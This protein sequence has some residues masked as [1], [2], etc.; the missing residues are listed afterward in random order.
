MFIRSLFLVAVSIPALSFAQSCPVG[1]VYDDCNHTSVGPGPCIPGCVA[2]GNP[3]PPVD[4]LTGPAELCIHEA[5]Q[6]VSYRWAGDLVIAESQL[7]NGYEVLG[8]AGPC[9]STDRAQCPD[10]LNQAFEDLRINALRANR[11]QFY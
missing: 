11:A 3:I 9:L 4:E 10:I 6:S 7:A 2:S 8:W 1:Q 5:C